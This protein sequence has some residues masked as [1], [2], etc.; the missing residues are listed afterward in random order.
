MM[1]VAY[2]DDLLAEAAITNWWNQRAATKAIR[3]HTTGS[4]LGKEQSV[5]KYCESLTVDG[6]MRVMQDNIVTS[7]PTFLVTPRM[8]KSC[9]WY[10]KSKY[11]LPEAKTK[12]AEEI[13]VTDNWMGNCRS[14]D[15]KWLGQKH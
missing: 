2:L 7:N 9:I 8:K 5:V 15:G 13:L 6:E 4:K 1:A 11:N 10:L 12:R 3:K 14:K